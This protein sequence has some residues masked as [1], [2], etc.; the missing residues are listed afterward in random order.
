[1]WDHFNHKGYITILHQRWSAAPVYEGMWGAKMFLWMLEEFV[2]ILGCLCEEDRDGH[3]VLG[4]ELL[5]LARIMC[6]SKRGGGR[7]SC[8]TSV[9]SID[10]LPASSPD[11]LECTIGVSKDTTSLDH[12]TWAGCDNPLVP[13]QSPPLYGFESYSQVVQH[14]VDKMF[15]GLHS[16][17]LAPTSVS[18]LINRKAKVR[19]HSPAEITTN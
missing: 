16:Q 5:L 3:M 6:C 11:T 17:C 14:L 4:H 15:K 9:L 7:G 12:L 19:C 18:I 13:R 2:Y 10:L 1:M 8:Y